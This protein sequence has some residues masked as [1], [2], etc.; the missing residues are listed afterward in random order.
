MSCLPKEAKWA[1]GMVMG[2]T[3]VKAGVDMM[4]DLLMKDKNGGEGKLPPEW[5]NVFPMSLDEASADLVAI[6]DHFKDLTVKDITSA[7]ERKNG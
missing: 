1:L 6:Q 7:L 4:L 3:I 5:G 2:A